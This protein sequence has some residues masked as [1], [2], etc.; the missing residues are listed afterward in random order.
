[1][2]KIKS[3]IFVLFI[4]LISLLT[5]CSSKA[6]N[7]S[8][9]WSHDEATHYHLGLD[10]AS[11]EKINVQNHIFDAWTITKE[12]TTTT[13]GLQMRKC[14]TC[15]YE[16][17]SVI[18]KIVDS[19]LEFSSLWSCDENSH[20]HD[21]LTTAAK[22]DESAHTFTE[23]VV[24]ATCDTFGYIEHTCSVCGYSYKSDYIDA[25][26]HDYT[27]CVITRMP[28]LKLKGIAKLKCNLDDYNYVIELPNL[29]EEEYIIVITPSTCNAEGNIEY[30]YKKYEF[31]KI[32]VS[33]SKIPHSFGEWTIDIPATNEADGHKYRICM[34]CGYKEED[35]IFAIG[36]IHTFSSDYT[37]DIDNPSKGH[38]HSSTCNHNVIDGLEDHTFESF[39][40]N[41][42]CLDKGFT[43]YTC[44]DCGYEYFS[45]YIDALGHDYVEVEKVEATEKADGY[46][47]YE[48][49][50]CKDIKY[51]E[52]KYSHIS[53]LL[54]LGIYDGTYYSL[55]T[56]DIL[57]DVTLLRQNLNSIVT[58]SNYVKR[59]YNKAFDDLNIVDSYDG[60]D[61]VECLYTGEKMDPNNHG[62][63]NRE[64]VWAKSH[65][66]KTADDSST[67]DGKRNNAYSDLHHLRASE[68]SINSTR[69]N[70]YFD[71][72][73]HQT[74]D[75][76]GN[77]WD[78]NNAFEPRDEVKG[79]IARMLF[80]MV[81]KYEGNEASQYLDLELTDDLT[82]A[83]TSINYV[84][85]TKEVIT[86]YLGKLSTLI[87]W[88]FEDPVDSRE[89]YRNNAIYN[90]QHNRN[91]FIDHPELVY[92][93]YKDESMELGYNANDLYEICTPNLKNDSNIA[94]VEALINSIG[95]VTTASGDAIN[96]ALEAYN[97]L[98]QVSKSFV[99][100]YKELNE[101]IETYTRLI[102]IQDP[103]ISAKFSF[104]TLK[105]NKTGELFN[106]KV[107]LS[108]VQNASTAPSDTYGIYSQ[109]GKNVTLDVIGL[110][111]SIKNIILV[112]DTKN[113]NID[114]T[115]TI[116]DGVNQVVKA[117]TPTVNVLTTLTIDVSNLDTTKNWNIVIST[118]TSWRIRSIE[119]SVE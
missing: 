74:G 70:R 104:L 11:N 29:N 32:N 101:M 75:D 64:H 24:E 12:P 10:E 80:Y 115:I 83:S 112:F 31:V 58:P 107:T 54:D 77:F 52:L 57:D 43:T 55:I 20:W 76:Y 59:S 78:K 66:I 67:S 108:Y 28:T 46:I 89:I 56:T 95:T 65:G 25:L 61:Y 42:T 84:Y 116:S 2:K 1:M 8:T 48:C 63:W 113:E 9:E 47:K 19:T 14:I 26:G 94:T 4:F 91:P 7:Y 110:Y 17:T 71:E 99:P 23:T 22:K 106:N 45:D 5:S 72:V 40:T 44:S 103:T 36:H 88:S 86:S 15:G 34:E 117:Y 82:L 98:D 68:N 41:P 79:D 37:Y 62:Y 92:Y 3:L 81:I 50:H 87:K 105:G 97:N 109:N 27:E 21:S 30:T 60:G 51:E 111:D 119:F 53:S 16:E 38:Y 39:I 69:N 85:N 73:S 118:K 33:I 114:G 6:H 35:V 93:L 13:E 102:A 18:P 100:N 90:I 96:N 49:S